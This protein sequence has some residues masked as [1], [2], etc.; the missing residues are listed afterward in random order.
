MKA[1]LLTAGICGGLYWANRLLLRNIA[2][3]AL[4]WFSSCYFGDILAGI[5]LPAL[6]S[7][8][9]LAARRPPLLRW[10]HIA[11]L[12]LAAGLVWECLAPLW[13][14]GAVFDWWDFPA[15]QV[16]GAVYWLLFRKTSQK[17]TGDQ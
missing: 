10:R 14:P 4:R 15:Y 3:G 11:L 6:V 16:G 13:K 12:L 7:L 17:Y 9:L 1:N 5:L 2:A 8:M